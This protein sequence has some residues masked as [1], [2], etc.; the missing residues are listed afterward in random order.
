MFVFCLLALCVASLP[1]MA[2]ETFFTDLGTGS[3][4]YNCCSG[5][6]V[7]GTNAPPGSFSAANL[8]TSL[9]TGN[10]TQIDLAVGYISGV[11]SFYAS[12]WTDNGGLPGTQLARWD[13]LS[14]STTF[15]QCCGLITISNISGLSL[16][17]GDQ[18]F[19]VLGPENLNSTTYMAWNWNSTGATGQDLYSRDGGA[20]WTSNG[21]QTLSAFD[22]IG[23]A[24]TTTTTGTT[25]E[26]SSLLLLG[27][28][29]VGA[30]S[31]IR[32]KLNR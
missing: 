25:P 23:G 10:V 12:I 3:N 17:A 2:D 4:A 26:P 9:A 7:S 32:R 6:T 14:S 15:G 20:T 8:F 19:M 24:T 31:T 13:N 11:N 1:A 27:T 21:E 16:T 30:F 28:G 5:W 29:L 18:Y 22:I